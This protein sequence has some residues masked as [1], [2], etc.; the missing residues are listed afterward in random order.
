VF[1][2]SVEFP[3]H[4]M[5]FAIDRHEGV[6]PWHVDQLPDVVRVTL[7]G[8]DRQGLA[9]WDRCELRMSRGVSRSFV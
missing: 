6:Q 5:H 8:G 4:L 9:R 1:R 3:E 2:C 7:Q